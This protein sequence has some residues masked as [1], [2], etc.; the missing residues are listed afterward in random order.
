MHLG[1]ANISKFRGLESEEENYEILKEKWHKTVTKRDTVILLG[2]ICFTEER[3]K[4]FSL[5]TAEQKILVAGNHCHTKGTELLTL[6]GWKPV[7]EICA[8]DKVATVELTSNEIFFEHPMRIVTNDCS[9]TYQVRG[10]WVDDVVSNN[11]HL[12]YENE[13]KSVA[14][15]EG[16]HSQKSF[17][18]AAHY[19]SDGIDIEENMLKLITWVVMDGCLVRSSE[20]KTRVQFKL[21]K[22]RKIESLENLLNSMEIP[23]TKREC[24]KSGINKLQPYYI[25]IY[26]QSSLKIHNILGGKK[27]LPSEWRDISRRQAMMFLGTLAETDGLSEFNKIRWTTTNKN[28]VDISQEFCV[29]NGIS[30]IFDEKYN[31][32]GFKNGKKQYRCSICVG[33][34][35]HSTKKVFVEKTG[36]SEKTYGVEMKHGTVISRRNGRV[37]VNGN[38]TD[39]ISMKTIVQYY[40]KVYSLL[41]YKGMWLSHAPIHPDEL[42]GKPNVHGHCH[43]HEIDDPRYLNV[44]VE[45]TEMMPVNIE[46]VRKLLVM[47]GVMREPV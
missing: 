29:K 18:T 28:D 30:F 8:S 23:Y 13:R 35:I 14:S 19:K 12:I 27:Q 17:T 46:L 26:G 20:R 7:Q 43:Y 21:S 25:T 37:M 45:H 40:D 39:R 3:L 24:K 33:T 2:D 15:L 31:K 42:R 44:C 22:T 9:E 34:N 38:C 4:D 32:S 47:R 16:T 6:S 10:G 36:V 11:H 1:H 5:W 41:K